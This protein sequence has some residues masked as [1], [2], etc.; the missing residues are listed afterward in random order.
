[1]IDGIS[2]SETLLDMT[3]CNTSNVTGAYPAN[4]SF[5]KVKDQRDNDNNVIAQGGLVFKSDANYMQM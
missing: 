4:L 1:M 2:L 5:Y 3:K